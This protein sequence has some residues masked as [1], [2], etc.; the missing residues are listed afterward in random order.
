M[1]GIE[2]IGKTGADNLHTK[3]P[4]VLAEMTGLEKAR[5]AEKA[6]QPERAKRY[7][8]EAVGLEALRQLSHKSFSTSQLQDALRKAVKSTR[9]TFGVETTRT[10]LIS[11][12]ISPGQFE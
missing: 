6:R 10:A 2:R 7:I 11:L 8:A 3:H 5:Q 4:K 1:Y 9:I 12:G